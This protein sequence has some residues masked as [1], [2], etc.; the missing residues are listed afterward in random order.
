MIKLLRHTLPD[1][2]NLLFYLNQHAVENV[3][4]RNTSISKC[5]GLLYKLSVL[6]NFQDVKGKQYYSIIYH[7]YLFRSKSLHYITTPQR[8]F[9]TT[10]T[11]V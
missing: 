11:S 3:L 9:I 10:Q 8:N 7:L 6:I 4:P 1:F 2:R 5:N